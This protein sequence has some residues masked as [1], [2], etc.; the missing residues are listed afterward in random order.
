MSI[1][2]LQLSS[3]PIFGVVY[4][5]ICCAP[6]H[7]HISNNL[8]TISTLGKEQ[9][10]LKLEQE[11]METCWLTNCGDLSFE[12]HEFFH[13]LIAEITA[14]LVV[15]LFLGLPWLKSDSCP[16]QTYIFIRIMIASSVHEISTL[17]SIPIIYLM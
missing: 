11:L 3:D 17:V 14:A 12:P 16:V 2:N 13:R 6:M 7:L 1:A 9:M 10:S 4:V 15:L 5:L 8:Q